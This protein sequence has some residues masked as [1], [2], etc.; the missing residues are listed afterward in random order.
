[1]SGENLIECGSVEITVESDSDGDVVVSLASVRGRMTA[2]L[3]PE[4]AEAL[5]ALLRLKADDAAQYK[6]DRCVL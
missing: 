1:M 2:Y 6:A 5:S 4:K 3:R